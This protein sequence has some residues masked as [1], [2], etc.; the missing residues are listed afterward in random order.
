MKKIIL[1]TILSFLIA[2]GTYAQTT[3][4]SDTNTKKQQVEN[5]KQKIAEVRQDAEQAIK[6]ARELAS[7]ARISTGVEIKGRRS[8]IKTAVQKLVEQKIETRINQAKENALGD[9]YITVRNLDNLNLRISSRIDKFEASG[10]ISMTESKNLLEIASTSIET[11]RIAVDNFSTT[12]FSTSSI[13]LETNSTSA[14]E[15]TLTQPIKDKVKEIKD[16][17]KE[18]HSALVDVVNSMVKGQISGTTTIE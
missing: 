14:V 11:V 3:T 16:L 4:V 10:T 7:S 15:K 17:I 12:D 13:A 2:S 5:A 8:E 18:A 1:I 6:N 9:F